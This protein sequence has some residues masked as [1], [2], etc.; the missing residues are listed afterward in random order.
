MTV[1]DCPRRS[2]C[3]DDRSLPC[4]RCRQV[5]QA[6]SRQDWWV[7]WGKHYLQSLQRAHELQQCNNFKD[8]GVQFYGG[9]LFRDVRDFADD[10]FCSL[11]APVPKPR[12]PQP[13]YNY[14]GGPYQQ[15]AA[16][17]A[18]PIAP[19]N[20]ASFN[21]RDQPCFHGDCRVAVLVDGGERVMRAVQRLRRGDRL[22]AGG[23]M[24]R[25]VVR[26][27]CP[28]GRASLVPIPA[29]AHDP[30]AQVLLVTPWH[31]VLVQAPGAAAPTWVF[32]AHVGAPVDVP[33]DAVYSLLVEVEG[34]AGGLEK[35]PRYASS[36]VVSGVPCLALA[37]GVAGDPVASHPFFGTR[38]VADALRRCQGWDQGM[39]HFAAAGDEVAVLVRDGLTG[40]VA[41]FAQAVDA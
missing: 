41:G 29:P 19:I 30:Q 35:D 37:H 20:M 7:R 17:P 38:A 33:C 24:V 34:S 10:Q 32:P 25:C 15:A 12:P 5:L 31:P 18:Q 28:A 2:A 39:V 4:T 11:P 1:N 21:S 14:G 26:T 6:L 16:A 22:A 40:L 36:V 27:A 3:A 23:G 8:P 9:A 13:T